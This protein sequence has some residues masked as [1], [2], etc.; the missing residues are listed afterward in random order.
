M[1]TKDRPE[2][3]SDVYDNAGNDFTESWNIMREK[4]EA[5]P[6]LDVFEKGLEQSHREGSDD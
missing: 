6:S 3:E 1:P 4:L 5:P 2:Y